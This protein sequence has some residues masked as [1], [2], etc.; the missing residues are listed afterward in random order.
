MLLCLHEHAK[1]AGELPNFKPS[2]AFVVSIP[3][4]AN[5]VG[6]PVGAQWAPLVPPNHHS[7]PPS[8]RLLPPNL[9]LNPR[10]R[11]SF[12]SLSLPPRTRPSLPLPFSLFPLSIFW[13][14]LLSARLLSLQCYLLSCFHWRPALG[15]ARVC[16]SNLSLW[17]SIWP[18]SN[19]CAFDP[20]RAKPLF[21]LPTIESSARK[22]W[23]PHSQAVARRRATWCEKSWERR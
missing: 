11:S 23:K 7:R 8:S 6:C 16:P 1:L 22:F 10:V 19:H 13:L 17:L 14:A 21:H 15:V 4:R 9:D 18:P 12:S 20:V 5:R 3:P 2:R